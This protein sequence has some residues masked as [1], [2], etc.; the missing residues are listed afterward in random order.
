MLVSWNVLV[1]VGDFLKTLNFQDFQKL[2][3]VPAFFLFFKF[4]EQ[5]VTLRDQ[6]GVVADAVRRCSNVHACVTFVLQ[7]EGDGF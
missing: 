7:Q 2:L 6:R 3:W 4:T 5:L 1:G